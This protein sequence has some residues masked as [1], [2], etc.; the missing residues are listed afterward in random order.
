MQIHP[1]MCVCDSSLRCLILSFSPLA[2]VDK[3]QD[4]ALSASC[5]EADLS[6]AFRF[7]VSPIS[8]MTLVWASFLCVFPFFLI[9]TLIH[10][11][12]TP[13]FLAG[14]WPVIVTNL[15]KRQGN[16]HWQWMC[17]ENESE[18]VKKLGIAILQFVSIPPCTSSLLPKPPSYL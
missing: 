7:G 1:F 9:C 13:L 8:F 5:L 17:Q 16:K 15:Q 4:L 14:I 6:L 18:S 12:S 2:G 3:V 10:P 11:H